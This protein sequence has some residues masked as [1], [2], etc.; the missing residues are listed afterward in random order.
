MKRALFT[1]ACLIAS[2]SSSALVLTFE[3]AGDGATLNNFYNGG[4]D[5]LGNSGTNF[6][7]A[8][9]S[10]ALTIIDQDAGGRGNIANEP[11]PSTVLF[12]TT[13]SAILNY[14]AG[15]DTGLSFFYSSGTAANVNIYDGLNGTGSLLATLSLMAQN[16]AN[17]C[18]GDPIGDFCNWTAIG[19]SFSGTAKSVDFGGTVN[20]V[21][22][23]NVTIGSATP[24][25]TGNIPEPSSLAL[26]AL[27][28]AGSA[29]ALR[30]KQ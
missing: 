17:N 28:L 25:P 21:G 15:F 29:F 5:S 8:F 24:E 20:F 2:G 11:S 14:A 10:D 30:R 16:T 1:L 23:D 26:L 18:V 7:V 19:T 22:Y 12:F 4:T 13:G 3:G 6:G 9:G 27:G